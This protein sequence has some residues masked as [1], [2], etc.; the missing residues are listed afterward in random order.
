MS[1]TILISTV[2]L[3]LLLAL[4]LVFIYTVDRNLKMEHYVG[5]TECES[6][7]KSGDLI[8]FQANNASNL[9]IFFMLGRWSHLGIVHRRLSDNRLFILDAGFFPRYMHFEKIICNYQHSDSRGVTAL[10]RL[11][12]PLSAEQEQLFE[13]FVRQQMCKSVAEDS[14]HPV[15][16]NQAGEWYGRLRPKNRLLP[17][18]LAQQL[19][20]CVAN[21]IMHEN[22]K[23]NETTVDLFCTD[24]VMRLLFALGIVNPAKVPAC[25]IPNFF[26][27][28]PYDSLNLAAMNQYYYEPE[29]EIK[30]M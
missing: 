28:Q 1:S 30:C 6:S 20:L 8:L 29:I 5:I 25:L 11:N 3:I 9:R 22:V 26:C 2:I 7:L 24:I 16:S 4:G 19:P 18:M 21:H 10:R 23:L 27:S 15:T 17:E 13:Q 12:R 14:I